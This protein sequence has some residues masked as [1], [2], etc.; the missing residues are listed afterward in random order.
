MFISNTATLTLTSPWHQNVWNYLFSVQTKWKLLGTRKN[1]PRAKWPT[2]C[3]IAQAA[4]GQCC[5]EPL[6]LSVYVKSISPDDFHLMLQQCTTSSGVALQSKHKN[7][8]FLCVPQYALNVPFLLAMS[9]PSII[10]PWH[11]NLQLQKLILLKEHIKGKCFWHDDEMKPSCTVKSFSLAIQRNRGPVQ[12]FGHLGG[13]NTASKWT[14]W[15]PKML[16][17]DVDTSATFIK[18]IKILLSPRNMAGWLT[19]SVIAFH[20]FEEMKSTLQISI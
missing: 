1:N 13:C 7:V 19:K 17:A 18:Q 16:M 11:Y 8:I 12:C 14:H 2:A 6:S 10:Q 3:T 15:T 9:C 4:W 5:G 20:I